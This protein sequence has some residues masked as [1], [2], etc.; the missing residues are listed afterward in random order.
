MLEP[1]LEPCGVTFACHEFLEVTTDQDE[2]VEQPPLFAMIASGASG[3][4]SGDFISKLR[5]SSASRVA[6]D[7]R[8][9]G[10]REACNLY[11]IELV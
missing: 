2:E 11:H 5:H 10:T 1:D 4:R 6:D 8:A 3:R 7:L 9:L